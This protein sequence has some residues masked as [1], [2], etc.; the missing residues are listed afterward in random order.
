MHDENTRDK[1]SAVVAV[2]SV[3]GN[4]SSG[5]KAWFCKAQGGEEA[6]VIV[7]PYPR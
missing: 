4:L 6:S 7:A 3:I 5:A 2:D 1:F